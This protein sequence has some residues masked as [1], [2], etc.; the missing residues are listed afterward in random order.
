MSIESKTRSA[1]DPLRSK[2]R[3]SRREVQRA[4]KL[5][6]FTLFTIYAATKSESVYVKEHMPPDLFYSIWGERFLFLGK[7]AYGLTAGL[8]FYALLLCKYH[9]NDEST[10]R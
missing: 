4:I 8:V 9:G 1:P 10:D 7:Y 5:V 2:A 3:P 6:S